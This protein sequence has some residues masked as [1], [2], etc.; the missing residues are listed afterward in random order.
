MGTVP[1]H[2]HPGV[3]SSGVCVSGSPHWDSLP[4]FQGLPSIFTFLF[5]YQPKMALLTLCYVPGTLNMCA[6]LIFPTTA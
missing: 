6:P 5:S 3:L 1:Q 4:F 2:M